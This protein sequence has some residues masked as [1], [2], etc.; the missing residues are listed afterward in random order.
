LSFDFPSHL[1]ILLFYE[2][3]ISLERN[4][5]IASRKGKEWPW[6]GPAALKTTVLL[7]H[8]LQG[9]LKLMEMNP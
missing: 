6:D 9:I 1:A 3:L 2:Q 4:K 7:L 5:E 8:L